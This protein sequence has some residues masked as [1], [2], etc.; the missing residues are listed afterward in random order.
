MHFSAS[1]NRFYLTTSRTEYEYKG[2]WPADAVEVSKKEHAIYAGEAPENMCRG[3]DDNGRP[4]WVPIPPLSIADLAHHKRKEIDTYRDQAFALGLPY[5]I[6]GKHD[7]V[8][9]RPQDQINLLALSSKAQR[10]IAVGDT[11]TLIKFRGLS[12]INHELTPEQIDAL[13][14]AALSHIE[15]IYQHSWNCKDAIDHAK[16]KND[17]K[18]IDIIKWF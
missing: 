7:V 18:S 12:N 14:M 1:N 10:L 15:N 5:E 17:R 6:A 13:T 11:K 2:E 9:T 16:A 3:S 8:Q 4:T